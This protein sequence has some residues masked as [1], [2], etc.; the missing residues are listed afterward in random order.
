MSQRNLFFF[1]LDSVSI[2][3][4]ICV[5][6]FFYFFFLL[7]FQFFIFASVYRHREYVENGLNHSS[8]SV[9]VSERFLNSCNF[10]TWRG[11]AACWRFKFKLCRASLESLERVSS[12]SGPLLLGCSSLRKTWVR[13]RN[14]WAR[15]SLHLPTS[16]FPVQQ[17]PSSNESLWSLIKRT[18]IHH[19]EGV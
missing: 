15:P 11:R 13:L 19:S 6:N 14:C 17:Y 7:I 5:F 4:L 12:I 8:F 10:I 16:F 18:Y 2:A 3:Y 9:F 1:V